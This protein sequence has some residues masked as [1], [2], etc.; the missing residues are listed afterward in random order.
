VIHSQKGIAAEQASTGEQ[1][2]L[3]IALVLAHAR[4]I[5]AERG[6]PP[7]LLLDEVV[8]HLDGERRRHLFEALLEIGAQAWMTG[9]DESLFRP[10]GGRAQFFRIKDA[11]IAGS[12]SAR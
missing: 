3:L 8:A 1:K 4:L 10:L 12:G 5:A 6:A 9:T 7:V 11:A 2:A